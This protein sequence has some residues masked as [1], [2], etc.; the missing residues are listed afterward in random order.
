MEPTPPFLLAVYVCLVRVG[1]I[2]KCCVGVHKDMSMNTTDQ[3][4]LSFVTQIFVRNF[5][6]MSNSENGSWHVERTK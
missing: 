5:L 6:L 4:A 2:N 3:D 1:I